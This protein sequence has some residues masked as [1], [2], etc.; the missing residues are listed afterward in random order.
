MISDASTRSQQLGLELWC[1]DEAGPFQTVPLAGTAWQPEGEPGRYPH[2]YVR[3][4]TAKLLT[5]FRPAD[6][7][8]RVK[9]VTHTTNEVLHPWLR[10]EL[11]QIVA[12]LPDMPPAPPDEPQRA[13]WTRWQDGLT[14]P[15]TLPATLPP[16]RILLIL[17]NLSGHLTPS[18]V[19][20]C[21]EHGIMPLYTPL[22]G[23]WL[24]MA[25]S[26]QR[27]L[28][29]RAL[30]GAHPRTPDDIIAWFEAVARAWNRQPT[31][32]VWGGTRAARRARARQRRHALPASG[33]CTRTPL[34]RLR[35]SA[36]DKYRSAESAESNADIH[37]G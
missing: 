24:N 8:V 17:D 25:E 34:P 18:F 10:Q 27:I 22:S 13:A 16:L 6:G 12:A 21:F 20:R 36:L 23:S 32:F 35:R 3:D 5:L 14:V 4:G 31:P 30:E 26:I 28:K 15:I 7:H 11:G 33:A 37:V 1:E 19:L 9:G 29:R 2:E